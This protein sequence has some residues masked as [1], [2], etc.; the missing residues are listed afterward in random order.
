MARSRCLLWHC[1]LCALPLSSAWAALHDEREARG[2]ACARD[3]RSSE[4]QRWTMCWPRE[5]FGGCDDPSRGVPAKVPGTVLA[6]M[7]G[8]NFSDLDPYMSMNLQQIPDIHQVGPEFYTVRYR[9]EV[10]AASCGLDSRT[11]LIRGVNYHAFVRVNGNVVGEV[12]GMFRRLSVS[13]P[14]TSF[15][16]EVDATP[17]PHYGLNVSG[18]GG[19]HDLAKDGPIPQFMLGWDWIQATPDRSTGLWDKI[20]IVEHKGALLRDVYVRFDIKPTSDGRHDVELA[21]EADADGG[22]CGLRWRVRHHAEAALDVVGSLTLPGC[23]GTKATLRDAKLWWPWQYG[24]PWLYTLEVLDG[25]DVVLRQDFGIRH[26]EVYYEPRTDGPAF[27]INGKRIFLAGVN[28]ITTDQLLRFAT[29]ATRYEN[30]VKLMKKAGANLIRVWGGGIAERPEFYEACD[31]LG[32]LV[33]QEFWMT[34]D[35]NGPQ[36]GSYDWP[37]DHGL[38]LDNVKDTVLLLRR[39]PSLFWWGGGNELWPADRNPP[40]DI[41]TATRQFVEELDGSRPFVQTSSL[42]QQ[43][44][45]YNPKD[46]LA[47]LSVDDGPYASQIPGEFFHRNPTLRYQFYPNRT[48]LEPFPLSINPELGGPNFPTYSGLRKFVHTK[49][50]PSRK[51]VYVP[52]EFTWHTFEAFNINTTQLHQAGSVDAVYDPIYDLWR[53]NQIT[54]SQEAYAARASLV[55]YVQYRSLFEGY[56]KNQWSWYAG[57]LLWKAQTPWPSLRGFIYDWYLETNSAHKAMQAALEKTDHVLVSLEPCVN[58]TAGLFRVNRAWETLPPAEVVVDFY[59]LPHGVHVSRSRFHSAAVQPEQVEQLGSLLWPAKDGAFLLRIKHRGETLEHI[60]SDPCNAEVLVP[61]MDYRN[62]D[63]RPLRLRATQN[64]SPKLFEATVVNSEANAALLVHPR[65]FDLQGQEVLPVFWS[66]DYFNLLPGES[67]TIT[68][69][70]GTPG[71]VEFTGFN[72]REDIDAET[73]VRRLGA[74]THAG[75]GGVDPSLLDSVLI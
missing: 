72:V 59:S 11:L 39:H 8:T 33:Y 74:H 6:T 55:Q 36:A 45:T 17:P 66:D 56:L 28:W 7:L 75:A 24:E 47:A 40:S 58:G 46:V 60:L 14:M 32:V 18:Q 41:T 48:G 29:D 2:H 43:M 23:A 63:E 73:L 3:L 50:T 67:R 70:G 53:D 25:E 68:W 38:Y 26:S 57:V 5:E 9:T 34:G 15:R 54:L 49:E 61:A 62:L 37:L 42:L 27:R 12:K 19:D 44:K 21:P 4:A 35:N 20:E 51:G 30:E 69:E 10:P 71:R 64:A 52:D 22:L 13:V 31:R 16:L 65:L 1:L